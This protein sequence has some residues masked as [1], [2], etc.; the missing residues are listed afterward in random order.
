MHVRRDSH[1]LQRARKI[2]DT[3]GFDYDQEN[4][5]PNNNLMA[6]WMESAK[7]VRDV[8]PKKILR[9][10]QYGPMPLKLQPEYSGDFLQKL[11]QRYRNKAAG[12]YDI[13]TP[14]DLLKHQEEPE[15]QDKQDYF[16]EFN[17]P[18]DGAGA[19][20]LKQYWDRGWEETDAPEFSEDKRLRMVWPKIPPRQLQEIME[21]KTQKV[22]NSFL[23]QDKTFVARRI[24]AN[25][26]LNFSPIEFPLDDPDGLRTAKKLEEFDKSLIYTKAKGWRKPESLGV[27]ARLMRAEPRA[28]RWTF[29]TTSG[30]DTYTTVFQFVPSKGIKDVKKLDVRCSCSCPSWLFWGAQYNAVMGDSL[31]GKIRPKFAPPMKRDPTGRFLVCKHVLAC[32]PVVGNYRLMAIA[33]GTRERLRKPVKKYEIE[34]EVPKEKIRV[35][36]ELET[37]GKRSDI[38]EAVKNWD[39]MSDADREEFIMNLESPGAV[40]Y[41]AHRLPETATEYVVPKLKN[42]ADED[43]LASNRRWAQRL[44][45]DIV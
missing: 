34:K 12:L 3:W 8:Q 24:I 7:G 19:D 1:S 36:R 11:L 15:I 28:G 14:S 26:L 17:R 42:M 18:G 6:E 23:E 20:T 2:A 4:L 35:P 21:K 25:F 5:F 39:K 32:L 27:S 41:M 9:E 22:I 44:L 40:S 43:K 31:Y 30:K 38:K 10:R 29:A 16:Y 13:D 37:F 33:P 45:R